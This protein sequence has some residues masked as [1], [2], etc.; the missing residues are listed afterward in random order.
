MPDL[1]LAKNE[2]SYNEFE[3]FYYEYTKD[4][5]NFE[6]LNNIKFSE[7]NKDTYNQYADLLNELLQNL[8][9][10]YNNNIYYNFFFS[11]AFTSY[12]SKPGVTKFNNTIKINNIFGTLIAY[13]LF[14]V[15]CSRAKKALNIIVERSKID[16]F[17]SEFKNKMEQL[18]FDVVE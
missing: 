12:L 4:I 9:Q 16:G 11:S 6:H 17:Y 3:N 7:L 14:Y 18:G 5:R 13:K 8:D 15:G 2:V 1:Q 10:K